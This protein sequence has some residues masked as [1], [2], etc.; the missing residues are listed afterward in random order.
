MVYIVLGILV[1]LSPVVLTQV[2]NVQQAR[3]AQQYA[4]EVARMD[5][6]QRADLLRR[7]HEYNARL[8]SGVPHDPWGTPADE[9]SPGYRDYLSQLNTNQTMARVRVPAV[10]IDLPV[11]HGTSQRVLASG[12]GHLYG[13]ALPVG[14]RGTHTVLTGHT[15]LATLTMFDNLT[16]IT[17]GDVFVID[18]AGEQL[19]YRVDQ[20]KVV[21]PTQL[22]D[23]A[24]DAGRDQ[25]TL[26]TCTPYGINTHRLL[27]R[28][29]RMDHVPTDLGQTYHSPWQPWMVGVI[30]VS[31]L[32]LL[33]LLWWLYDRRRRDREQERRQREQYALDRR[34]EPPVAPAPPA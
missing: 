30:V 34:D 14:G 16:H 26:V 8:A 27:V 25:A 3:I 1:L 24:P 32:A 29:Q 28:G 20:V 13:T 17:A 19:A 31:L 11:Q 23:L 12:V 22:D 10:G 2:N 4:R 21:L 15:G 9:D 33:Y 6:A 18:V 5:A 7:A